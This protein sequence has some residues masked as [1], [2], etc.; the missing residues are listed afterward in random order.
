LFQSQFFRFIPVATVFVIV[1][2]LTSSPVR[3]DAL[4]DTVTQ[5]SRCAGAMN[6]IAEHQDDP[7]ARAKYTQASSILESMGRLYGTMGDLDDL[8]AMDAVDE[9]RREITSIIMAKD[10]K[11]HQAFMKPCLEVIKNLPAHERESVSASAA[12]TDLENG[13]TAKA[14]AFL[15]DYPQSPLASHVQIKLENEKK[16]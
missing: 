7:T 13:D 15:A 16:P 6:S 10:G 1:L 12:L 11:S 2:G 4:T 3:A 14:E 9:G 8:V 5:Y